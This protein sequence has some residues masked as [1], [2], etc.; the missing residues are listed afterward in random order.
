MLLDELVSNRGANILV[1]LSGMKSSRSPGSNAISTLSTIACS[2]NVNLAITYP[3][4]LSN[5]NVIY[6]HYGGLHQKSWTSPNPIFGRQPQL[7]RQGVIRDL[8]EESWRPGLSVQTSVA[9][10]MIVLR[11]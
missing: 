6:P 8:S 2:S 5:C 10:S 7:C 9:A 3:K 1:F 11:R 4:E